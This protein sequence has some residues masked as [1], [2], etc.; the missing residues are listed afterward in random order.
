MNHDAALQPSALLTG[1]LKS[2][3]NGLTIFVPGIAAMFSAMPIVVTL[4]KDP[5][6]TF[7]EVVMRFAF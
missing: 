1:T 4:S 5:A 3:I 2:P 7:K 6:P